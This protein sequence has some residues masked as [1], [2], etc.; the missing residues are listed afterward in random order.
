MKAISSVC[1]HF[2][3]VSFAIYTDGV[4]LYHHRVKKNSLFCEDA[5]IKINRRSLKLTDEIREIFREVRDGLRGEQCQ[6]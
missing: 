6:P 4:R 2:H 3:L 5:M 1:M